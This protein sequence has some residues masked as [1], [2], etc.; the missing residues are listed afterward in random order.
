MVL[1]EKLFEN[2]DTH[3]RKTEVY[4]SYNLTSEGSGEL[5]TQILEFMM[6][7]SL[8]QFKQYIIH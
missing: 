3:T 5:K 2:V 7:K 1:E 6:L 8:F 4:L